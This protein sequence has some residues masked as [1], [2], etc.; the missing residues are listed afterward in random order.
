MILTSSKTNIVQQTTDLR[1]REKLY[2]YLN[3]AFFEKQ[4]CDCIF[5]VHIIKTK[6]YVASYTHPFKK[7]KTW[8]I[9]NNMSVLTMMNWLKH[10]FCEQQLTRQVFHSFCTATSANQ[11]HLY[12]GRWTNELRNEQ[13]YNSITFCLMPWLWRKTLINIV[14]LHL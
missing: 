9:R 4:L 6:L 2:E 13:T 11:L 12:K 1:C 7:S 10:V 8:E 5:I 14:L 3:T